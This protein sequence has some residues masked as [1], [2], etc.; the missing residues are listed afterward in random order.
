[1]I[2]PDQL[3]SALESTAGTGPGQATV[4]LPAGL[5]VLD[6]LPLPGDETTQPLP[7][8]QD[9][10]AAELGAV[11]QVIV[12][13]PDATLALKAGMPLRPEEEGSTR[14][15]PAQDLAASTL[16]LPTGL[17]EAPP[18]A[19]TQVMRTGGPDIP[20]P[21]STL[22]LATGLPATPAD[23]PEVR[24][25]EIPPDQLPSTPQKKRSLWPWAALAGLT[26]GLVAAGLYFLRPELLGFAPSHAGEAEAAESRPA[27]PEPQA[28]PQSP[29]SPAPEI[30]PALRSYLDKAEKGDPAAMRMLGVMYYNGLNVPRNEREGLKWYRKAADAGSKAAQKEL[31]QMGV[32]R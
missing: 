12:G 24:T 15:F 31:K 21:G 1:M 22:V 4:A 23:L 26:L 25:V 8:A 9:R 30:P 32:E 11:A 16:A 28:I 19:T 7:L 3:R 20:E 14:I 18:S 10:S 29:E 13:A 5:P 27:A 6:P 17:P 2:S